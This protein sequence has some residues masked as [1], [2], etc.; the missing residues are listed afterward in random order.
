MVVYLKGILLSSFQIIF[1]IILYKCLV[2]LILISP[3][4]FDQN[5]PFT[6]DLLSQL[7][8][9]VIILPYK[10][11]TSNLIN[12]NFFLLLYYVTYTC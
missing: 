6:S 9:E 8:R 7:S 2:V 4:I 1:R 5:M 10:N 12:L 11:L 3:Y